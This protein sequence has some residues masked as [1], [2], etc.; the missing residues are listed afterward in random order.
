MG[1]C[2]IWAVYV[3]GALRVRV[4]V[5]GV[6]QGMA[7][8]SRITSHHRHLDRVEA[9]AV[10]VVSHTGVSSDTCDTAPIKLPCG[11]GYCPG[12][13][14]LD[15]CA[16]RHAQSGFAAWFVTEAAMIAPQRE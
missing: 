12:E 15:E 10:D 7:A 16:E 5:S 14:Y 4:R 11:D 1:P 2:W 8:S 3:V 6:R 9:P 13:E